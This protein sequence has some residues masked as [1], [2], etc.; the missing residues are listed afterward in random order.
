MGSG[1]S[2]CGGPRHGASAIFLAIGACSPAGTPAPPERLPSLAG[3]EW[4]LVAIEGAEIA[5]GPNVT[6]EIEGGRLGGH[7]T[8]N[9][10]GSEYV[11][12]DGRLELGLVESTARGCADPALEP[13][14]PPPCAGPSPGRGS[15]SPTAPR[16]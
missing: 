1:A 14:R 7:A 15:R 12:E 2:P 11:A 8:C 10:Y 16:R 4:R 6:L 5:P 9:W 3:T 13:T